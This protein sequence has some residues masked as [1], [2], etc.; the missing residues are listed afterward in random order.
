MVLE[1][2][3]HHPRTRKN[4]EGASSARAR[5]TSL[6]IVLRIVTMMMMTRKTRRR[7]KRKRR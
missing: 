5:I 3:E 4:Q 6:W 7:T 2:R 1:R